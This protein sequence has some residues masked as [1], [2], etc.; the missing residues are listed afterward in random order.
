MAEHKIKLQKN[1]ILT[2]KT[3]LIGFYSFTVL[4]D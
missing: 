1:K 4:G 3:K 2:L